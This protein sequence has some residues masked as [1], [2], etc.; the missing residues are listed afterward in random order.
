V[1]VSRSAACQDSARDRLWHP[2]RGAGMASSPQTRG[3]RRRYDSWH[4]TRWLVQWV[5]AKAI[6]ASEGDLVG[7]TNSGRSMPPTALR[8]SCFL[9]RP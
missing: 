3:I 9:P 6:E 7:A 4:K 2:L 5:I 1:A 8:E